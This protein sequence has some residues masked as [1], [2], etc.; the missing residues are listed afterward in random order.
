MQEDQVGWGWHPPRTLCQS[1]TPPVRWMKGSK[2]FNLVTFCIDRLLLIF[3][4]AKCPTL[5]VLNSLLIQIYKTKQFEC[6][7]IARNIQNIDLI[8]QLEKWLPFCVCV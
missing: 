3:Y 7:L 8:P 6:A 5:I 2:I 1:S 4:S